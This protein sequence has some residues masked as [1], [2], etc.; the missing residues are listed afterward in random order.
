ML[1]APPRSLVDAD[2]LA[3]LTGPPRAGGGWLVN[4]GR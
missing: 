3:A 1:C 2:V 4:V